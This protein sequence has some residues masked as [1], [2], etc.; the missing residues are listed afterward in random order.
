MGLSTRGDTQQNHCHDFSGPRC[1]VPRPLP[2]WDRFSPSAV[3]SAVASHT[4]LR[5]AGAA[6]PG[7]ASPEV[8]VEKPP[9]AL[10]LEVRRHRLGDVGAGAVQ[11][12][13]GGSRDMTEVRTTLSA[14]EEGTRPG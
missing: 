11:L 9:L 13:G 1:C 2:C 4:Y 7:L 6:D 14:L 10:E 3:V 12:A 8:D 5:E